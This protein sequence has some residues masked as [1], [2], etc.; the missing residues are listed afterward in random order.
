MCAAKP[1]R[2]GFTL[3]ELLVVIAI[4]AILGALILPALGRAKEKAKRVRCFSNER[5]LM[6]AWQFYIVDNS[7]RLVPNGQHMNPPDTKN[8]FWVQ[9]A[10][11]DTAYNTQDKFVVDPSYALFAV[12][13]RSPGVY[14]CPTDPPTVSYNGREYQRAR[15]YALNYLVGWTGPGDSRLA[16]Q[17][18]KIFRRQADLSVAMPAGT[19]TFLDVHPKSICWPYFGVYMGQD[20]FFNFPSSSH[21]QGAVLSY[22]DGH[23]AWHKWVDPRTIAA[24][25]TSTPL[26]YHGHNDSSPGNADIAWLRERTTVRTSILGQ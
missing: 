6:L 1:D 23:A 15:S 24:V 8:R 26:P 9:G 2:R 16:Y 17:A 21:N 19:F 4:I 13:I 3:I 11:Y 14:V 12:Y 7:D 10:F 5:Q 25:S 22:A 20:K 18:L